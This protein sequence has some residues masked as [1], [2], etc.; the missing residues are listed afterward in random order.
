MSPDLY[1]ASNHLMGPADVYP[2]SAYLPR[3]AND[4][5]TNNNYLPSV[6]YSLDHLDR[7]EFQVTSGPV[8]FHFHPVGLKVLNVFFCFISGSGNVALPAK[9]RELPDWLLQLRGGGA[10]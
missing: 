10:G 2:P 9:L 3:P 8:P 4:Q 7:L 1:P 6:S 5:R